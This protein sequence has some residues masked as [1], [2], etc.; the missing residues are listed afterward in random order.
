MRKI[1]IRSR[2]VEKY[3]SKIWYKMSTL[4]F[5]LDSGKQTDERICVQAMHFFMG[6]RKT[7][8]GDNMTN[9]RIKIM[10][11]CHD[12][13]LKNLRSSCIIFI[14]DSGM[15]KSE[16]VRLFGKM[17]DGVWLI[18]SASESDI[19]DKFKKH[20]NIIS[21]VLDEPFDWNTRDYFRVAMMLKHILEHKIQPPRSTIFRDGSPLPKENE[22]AI[23]VFCNEEQYNT[24]KKSLAGTGLLE[25]AIVVKTTHTL[26]EHDRIENHY[27][28]VGKN[29]VCY[30]LD[31]FSTISRDLDADEKKWVQTYF[32]GFR[33]RTAMWIAKSL[34]KDEF[35]RIK[36]F[37]VSDLEG[38]YVRES[39]EF[40]DN[41]PPTNE[42]DEVTT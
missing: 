6:N 32:S 3:G 31:G 2:S 36:P 28:K 1:Y 16:T 17:K 21:F 29:N 5:T 34:S 8:F 19:V 11:T 20:R 40:S 38:C 35:E 27:E 39:I 24:I 22:S 9:E 13:A 7:C 41:E 25:R 15:G 26:D 33:G 42:S 4:R 12:L 10:L 30:G 37:L 14:S 18:P 23:F